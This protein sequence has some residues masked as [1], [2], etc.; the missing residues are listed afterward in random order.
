MK[1][2]PVWILVAQCLLLVYVFVSW[3]YLQ[4]SSVLTFR[5]EKKTKHVAVGKVHHLSCVLGNAPYRNQ[6]LHATLRKHCQF[7]TSYLGWSSSEDA[8]GK[9]RLRLERLETYT[10]LHDYMT[11][12]SILVVTGILWRRITPISQAS[13]SWTPKTHPPYPL[14]S[15]DTFDI[16]TPHLFLLPPKNGWPIFTSP[17]GT[18]V[19]TILPVLK[20]RQPPK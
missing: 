8:S 18:S 5:A 11:W 3:L 2:G 1:G 20:I 7:V 9:R 15:Q 13:W 10:F 12:E 17:W 4:V 14:N 19:M 6:S 16:P